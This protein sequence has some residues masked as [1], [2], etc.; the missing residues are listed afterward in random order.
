MVEYDIKQILVAPGDVEFV[1]LEEGHEHLVPS[2]WNGRHVVLFGGG[3]KTLKILVSILPALQ[4]R[5]QKRKVNIDLY[6]LTPVVQQL[7][8]VYFRRY[9]KYLKCILIDKHNSTCRLFWNYSRDTNHQAI[10]NK[11]N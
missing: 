7:D 3:N 8:I 9:Q 10:R 2:Q 5:R 11:D 4:K 1:L 6:W